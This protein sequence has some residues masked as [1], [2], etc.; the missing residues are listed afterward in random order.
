MSELT[1]TKASVENLQ[2]AVRLFD[3]YRQFYGQPAEPEGAR[4]FLTERLTKGES[5]IFLALK[6]D[7]A[8]GFA[9]LYPSFSSLAMK[10]IWILNDLFVSPS[11]RG[12][13]VGTRLLEEC[14]KLAIE[15]EAKELVLE[16]MKTNTT[17][18]SLYEGRGWKR[19][20]IF[21]RYSLVI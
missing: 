12:G 11:R 5:V 17:A 10:P 21:Y 9:Q 7:N 1:I 8:V 3:A 16:T 4:R 6:N 15:T 20:E 19:D 2:D 18:Q 14:K 13:G